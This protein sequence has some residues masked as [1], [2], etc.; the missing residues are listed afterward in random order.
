[1]QNAWDVIVVGA[2]PAG[3]SVARKIAE[4]GYSVLVLDKKK[5]IGEPNHC[6]EGISINC[7]NEVGVRPP[8]SWILREVKGGRLIFPNGTTIY[9]PK[10]GYCIDRPSFDRFLADRAA[11]AGAEVRTSTTVKWIRGE[12]SG[13]VV[14][15]ES[16][17]FRGRYLV[18]A[19][20]ALCPVA[21]Y[22]G[23][24][25]P[26]L[27]ALQYKFKAADALCNDWLQF[28]HHEEFKG[29]YAWV[30]HRGKE[31]SVGAGSP[32]DLK[33]RL[34][35]F[36]RR[37]GLNPDERTKTEGGPIPFLKRPLQ[38][39]FPRALLAGDAGGFTYPFTKGGVHGA[40]WSGR[41]AGEVIAEALKKDDSYLLSEY[42]HRVRI[43]PCR[44]PLHLMIPQAFFRFDNRIINTIGNIMDGK[45]YTEI[46]VIRFLRYFLRHPSPRILWGI[47]IGFAVQRFY[48]KSEPFAW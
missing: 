45:N 36:C 27:P 28:H 12:R 47:A 9:F 37:A 7:L 22:F 29:G 5:A 46:P 33:A 1:M 31:L 35:R 14:M 21:G 39:A 2:G 16:G 25:S 15:T 43:Y 19:G 13:W 18:G 3:S 17:E 24:R 10:K 48:H 23:Q 6:G 42:P 4:S 20:G 8:Q 26:I 38:I 34:E 40:V 30:F 32:Q 11:K 44:D 41:I